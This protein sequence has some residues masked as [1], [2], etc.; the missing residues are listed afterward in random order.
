[1][2]DHVAHSERSVSPAPALSPTF[3]TASAPSLDRP[4]SAMSASSSGSGSG[5]GGSSS[6]SSRLS[7]G[8]I[9]N[10][11]R[12]YMRP[13]GTEFA[14]S[15]KNRE[16]V[17]SLGTI[18]HLQYYFARTGLLDDKGGRIAKERRK[19]KRAEE[20]TDGPNTTADRAHSDFSLKLDDDASSKRSSF[21][22]DDGSMFAESIDIPFVDSPV[23]YAPPPMLPPTVSTYRHKVMYT[24]PPPAITVLRRELREALQDA[25]DILE[26]TRTA[27][28]LEKYKTKSAK[29]E[30]IARQEWTELQGLDILDN[31]TLAIKA[32]KNYYTA[33]EKPQMLYS[34]KPEKTIRKELYEVLE[35]LK[36]MAGR[37]FEGGIRED[38]R[39]AIDDWIK[40]IESLLDKEEA[41]EQAEEAER[42]K[43]SWR[44]GDWTGRERE[45]ERLFLKSFDPDDAV[46]ELPAWT[47][48][49]SAGELPTPFLHKLHSGLRLV[50]L[51]NELVRKSRRQFE[52]IKTFHTDTSLPYRC[53]ENLR[54]WVKAAELRWE[55]KLKVDVMEVVHGERPEAWMQ[56][57]EALLKWCKGVREEITREWREQR[58][59]TTTTRTPTLKI[60][61]E[62]TGVPAG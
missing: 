51:H 56:F 5:S 45:R 49:A 20:A 44:E 8:G 43:W 48:A 11:R 34:I 24:A 59:K 23:D 30:K 25:R 42:E 21:I 6:K 3:M 54:Y 58:I 39:H 38:E 29:T 33:H 15:A 36:R 22:S 52:E 12:G 32:A 28:S 55:I 7:W 14:D 9:P 10:G 46:D 50:Y 4:V 60:D 37:D 40:D 26:K 53:A 13:E 61:S 1:M 2:N 18:S 27:E 41:K 47:D 57:D 19:K 16:S 31:I 35:V 17:Q 62:G